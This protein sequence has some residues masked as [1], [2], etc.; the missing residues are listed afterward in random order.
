MY[1][2]ICIYYYHDDDDYYC[3]SLNR[4]KLKKAINNL[5]STPTLQASEN[6]SKKSSKEKLVRSIPAEQRPP[7]SDVACYQPGGGSRT[8]CDIDVS[9]MSPVG[10]VQVVPCDT[11]K[12]GGYT[13]DMEGAG[14]Y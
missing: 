11:K 12:G 9:V 7:T 8:V 13:E 4:Y 1:I 14:I 2:Y 5:L 6:W 3:Y 10:G